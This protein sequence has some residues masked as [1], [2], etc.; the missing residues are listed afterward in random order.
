MSEQTDAGAPI[1]PAY[2]LLH[3]RWT[4]PAREWS[5]WTFLLVGIVILGGLAVWIE[6]VRYFNDVPK[7]NE[8]SDI[9]PLQLALATA[10]LAVAGPSAMQMLYSRDKLTIV[11]AILLFT[12]EMI[13]SMYLMVFG[14]AKAC[15]TFVAGLVCVVAAIVSWVLANGDDVIFQDETP[16]DA[17]AGG[18][19]MRPL[20]TGSSPAAV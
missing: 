9:A 7:P 8:Q 1:K 15:G 3:S 19:P 14:E 17:A 11:A 13:F 2:R 10:G 12:V 5:F 4:S 16:N 18:N 6:G 20:G